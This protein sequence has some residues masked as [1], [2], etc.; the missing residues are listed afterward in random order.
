[1]RGAHQHRY[2]KTWVT[3]QNKTNIYTKDL[4]STSYSS[5][6]FNGM[7]KGRK[8]NNKHTYT[9]TFTTVFAKKRSHK[10]KHKT[11]I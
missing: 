9:I 6:K 7:A 1:M 3:K 4:K 8:D 2:C 11:A 5:C 10:G